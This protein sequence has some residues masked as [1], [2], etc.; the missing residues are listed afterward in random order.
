MYFSLTL[1]LFLS[2]LLLL[3]SKGNDKGSQ[4]RSGI[5]YT[6][7]EQGALCKTFLQKKKNE[8]KEDIATKEKKPWTKIHTECLPAVVFYEAEDYHQQYLAKGGKKGNLQAAF[9]GCTDPIR[10]YG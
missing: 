3:F 5:Y 1:L 6:T 2:S 10:C 7:P 4:Y 9:K 8:L